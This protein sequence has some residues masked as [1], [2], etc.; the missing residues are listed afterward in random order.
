M[1]SLH[2][3]ISTEVT[4]RLKG[5]IEIESWKWKF[6]SGRFCIFFRIKTVIKLYTGWL[7]NIQYLLGS[8]LIYIEIF[9]FI[10]NI[11][12]IVRISLVITKFFYSRQVR[13]YKDDNTKKKLVLFERWQHSLKTKQK[14]STTYILVQLMKN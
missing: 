1:S 8:Y 11:L 9:P 7:V 14:Y 5:K 6:A 4:K 3:L 13:S 2:Y 12:L 10:F